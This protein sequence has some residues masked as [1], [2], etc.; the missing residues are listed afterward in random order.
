MGF[1]FDTDMYFVSSTL[2]RA[3][4]IKDLHATPVPTLVSM[5][6]D[7]F[8]EIF[9][10]CRCFPPSEIIALNQTKPQVY[11]FMWLSCMCT[12]LY[13]FS[14]HIFRDGGV[15]SPAAS[16]LTYKWSFD[17]LLLTVN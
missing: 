5:A 7:P 4:K 13:S 6:T 2:K 11:M 1:L 17:S 8:F 9:I 15:K 3:S 16:V 14:Q 12:Q 10:L